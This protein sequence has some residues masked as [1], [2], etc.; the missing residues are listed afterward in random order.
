MMGILSAPRYVLRVNGILLHED[1]TRH[2]ESIQYTLAERASDTLIIKLNAQDLRFVNTKLFSE[3]NIIRVHM[4]YGNSLQVL[5]QCVVVKSSP[6]FPREGP[7]SLIVKAF[8]GEKVLDVEPKI[9]SRQITQVTPAYYITQ[10]ARE[11]D[12]IPVVEAQEDQRDF[13]I[14]PGVTYAKYLREL[15]DELGY[16]FFVG[17][18]EETELFTLHFHRPGDNVDKTSYKFEYGNSSLLDF[19]SEENVD[20]QITEL[21]LVAWEPIEGRPYLIKA[22]L[23]ENEKK[24]EIEFTVKKGDPD[25]KLEQPLLDGA[26]VRFAIFGATRLVELPLVAKVG[27]LKNIVER[28]FEEFRKSFVRGQGSCIG[29]AS[30]RPGQ[31]HLFSGMGR[32]GGEYYLTSVTHKFAETFETSF[33]AFRIPE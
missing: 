10:I 28:K 12:M 14:N 27:D 29:E 2:I 33:S 13:F 16:E 7:I 5:G 26:A 20:N 17:S 22:E 9:L 1:V 24:K 3:G 25:M 30:L 21:S 19:E 23:K 18:D 11:F 8:G 32:F 31:T 4:G 15:A 6:S